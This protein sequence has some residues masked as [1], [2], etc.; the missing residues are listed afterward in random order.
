MSNKEINRRRPYYD[1]GPIPHQSLSKDE[2]KT[3]V[4]VCDL[5]MEI[6]QLAEHSPSAA[7]NRNNSTDNV[8]ATTTLKLNNVILLDGARGVGKTSLMLT[9]I[10]ALS[11]PQEW[12]KEESNDNF[13]LPGDIDKSVRVMRQIDFDPLPPDLPIYSWIVQAFYPMVKNSIPD[14]PVSFIEDDSFGENNESIAVQHGKLRQTATVGWTTGLLKNQLGKDAAEF[15]MWQQEQQ[16]DWQRLQKLWHNFIDNLLKIL[17]NL[18]HCN[19]L[20]LPRNCL[21]VLPIDD[22]DLQVTRTRE[23]LLALRVL[24]HNRLVYLLTGDVKNTDLAL[25]ASFYRDFIDRTSD[26]NDGV[27]DKIWE[28][29]TSLGR[30][31]RDKTIPSSQIFVIEPVAINVALEWVPPVHNTNQRQK[32]NEIFREILNN[33]PIFN[34]GQI[35]LGDYLA[36]RPAEEQLNPKLTFR[37]LQGFSD[38]WSGQT[39]SSFDAVEEFLKLVLQDPLEEELIVAT[40]QRADSH[41]GQVIKLTGEFSRSAAVSDNIEKIDENDTTIKWLTQLDFY[42][43][44]FRSREPVGSDDTESNPINPASPNF[45]LAYDLV[46]DYSN[47]IEID[48]NIK[49][50]GCPLGFVWSEFRIKESTYLAPWPMLRKHDSPSKFFEYHQDWMNML[51]KFQ[52][53]NGDIT[54]DLLKSTWCK[55][56][57]IDD[58]KLNKELSV[59]LD[60]LTYRYSQNSSKTLLVINDLC[61]KLDSY[62]SLWQKF[63]KPQLYELAEPGDDFDYCNFV[64]HLPPSKC[65]QI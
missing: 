16:M 57:K 59:V 52:T 23:L 9:L 31:L 24:R 21:I 53:P 37:K 4:E 1:T 58:K 48:R 60:L 18:D 20:S 6:K 36:S 3:I 28:K 51:R 10:N 14:M 35:K 46:S 55:L 27:L 40:E 63:T 44:I 50:I 5:L 65:K 22:L 43:K 47:L 34:E 64:F 41:F 39:D 42:Q 54:Y 26:W 32:D 7:C 38:K 30:P 49:F 61:A 19:S 12:N 25:T 29:S 15:L 62:T 45:L 17:E 33:L 11:N 2:Q 13:N 8:W 56:N